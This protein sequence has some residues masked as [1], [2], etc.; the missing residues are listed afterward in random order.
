MRS[1]L[2]ADP[3]PPATSLA[4]RWLA[5]YLV[6]A[7]LQRAAMRPVMPMAV[8]TSALR[9][10]V[11]A[12]DVRAMAKLVAARVGSRVMVSVSRVMMPRMMAPTSAASPM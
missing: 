12:S 10:L 7:S 2:D 3:K 5:R 4:R 11:S 8:S 1:T 6:L 9:R